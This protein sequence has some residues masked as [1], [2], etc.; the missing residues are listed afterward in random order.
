M[1]ETFYAGHDFKWM[2]KFLNAIPKKH[3]FRQSIAFALAACIHHQF[4]YTRQSIF[5]LSHKTLESFGIERRCL[6]PYLFLFQK[7]GLL[8]YTIKKGTSPII[9]LIVLPT[10]Y[11]IINNKTIKQYIIKGTGVH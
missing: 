3:R 7:A 8:D 5:N 4:V 11:Y 10:N 2:N 6:K 1:N 9:Q